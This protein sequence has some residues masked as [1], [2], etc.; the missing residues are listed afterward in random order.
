MAP[1]SFAKERTWRVRSPLDR[2]SGPPLEAVAEGRADERRAISDFSYRAVRA[3]PKREMSK[4]RLM[5]VPAPTAGRGRP[6][7]FEGMSIVAIN[8]NIEFRRPPW[9]VELFDLL[10]PCRQ[11]ILVVADG[12]INYHPSEGLGLTEL[13]NA[14]ADPAFVPRVPEVTRA[15]R[16]PGAGS[17]AALTGFRFDTAAV[18]LTR[19]NYDQLWLIGIA[20]GTAQNA[21]SGAYNAFNA[22]NDNEIGVIAAF[23]EAGGGVFATGDHGALGFSLSGLLPR[24]RHMR[25]WRTTPMGLESVP[26][27]LGRLD[28]MSDPGPEK[29]YQFDDQS[30]DRPQRVFPHYRRNAMGNWVVHPLLSSGSGD[31]DVLPD[32]AHESECRGLTA[33]TGMFPAKGATPAFTEFPSATGATPLPEIVATAI[34]GGRQIET[35]VGVKPPPTPR[36]FGAIS[37]Y[38]G[39]AANK[40]RIVC[41]ATW[42]HLVNVNLNGV[43]SPVFGPGFDGSAAR[44]GMRDAMGAPTAN[45][46][47]IKRYF[48]N[49]VR[50]LAPKNR[51]TCGVLS[52]LVVARFTPPLVEEIPELV[53]FP[54]PG[55]DPL[56]D[57]RRVAL[58]KAAFA[59]LASNYGLAGASEIVA[60]L[61]DI[62]DG[63]RQLNA[64]LRAD[65]DGDLMPLGEMHLAALGGV[66]EHLVREL[67]ESPY[68]E[69]F[70]RA[71]KKLATADRIDRV[72]A[73]GVR[74]G[75]QSAAE[76]IH[77][78]LEATRDL[79]RRVAVDAGTGKPPGKSPRS[80]RV[81]ATQAAD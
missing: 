5:P 2:P 58:G 50:W 59:V 33:G 55:P 17:G 36:S 34:S 6:R 67:P 61:V 21:N 4:R 53:P 72:L 37:A 13:L 57:R 31:I 20:S 76:G 64:A 3:T 44:T 51:R 74:R 41:Q 54:P 81:R 43:G 23:M 10:R 62:D 66:M 12:G 77:R 7:H 39:D 73:E 30:D 11:R 19:A 80:T 48:G 14:L 56:D 60:D 24:I 47:Q 15:H 22:L 32:H 16:S 71:I 29:N 65:T 52:D 1:G 70:R 8:P 68:G 42:H 69:D 79:L 46:L 27:A 63:G 40:G 35:S 75:T 38:D 18:P 78:R 49:L 45:Y 25:E 28:T 26:T 9:V